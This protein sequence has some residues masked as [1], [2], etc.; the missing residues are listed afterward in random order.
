MNISNTLTKLATLSLLALLSLAPRVQAMP[1][2]AALEKARPL[3]QELMADDFAALKADKKTH[4]AV[5]DAAMKLLSNA[6]TEAAKFLLCKAAFGLY[7]RGKAYDKAADVL[8]TFRESISD[9]PTADLV[10]KNAT[11]Y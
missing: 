7:I 3:I 6:E 11:A 2:P 1:T 8:E 5:G 9:L 10:Q 4:E